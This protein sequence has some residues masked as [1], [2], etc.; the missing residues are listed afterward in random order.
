M[1]EIAQ[2]IIRNKIDIMAVQEIRWH[3]TG[4]IDKPEFTQIYSR[5]EDRTVQLGTGF[6]MTRKIKESMLECEAINEKI[7]R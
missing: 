7:C 3:G 4:R 2:E 6:I 1:K 5:S